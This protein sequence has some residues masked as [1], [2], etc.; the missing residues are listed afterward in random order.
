MENILAAVPPMGWNSW[1]TFGEEFD[2]EVIMQM[3]DVM[4]DKGYLDCG[5]EYL[6][7]DDCWAELSRDESG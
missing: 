5:Y 3:A 7:L 4:A 6:I 1:N 2:A